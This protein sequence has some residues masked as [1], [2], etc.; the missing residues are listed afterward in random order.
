MQAQILFQKRK[1]R[2]IPMGTSYHLVT[3]SCSYAV[4]GLLAATL[5]EI[6]VSNHDIKLM[7]ARFDDWMLLLS[8]EEKC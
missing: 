1:C 7:G 4:R 2:H 6:R 3:T 8:C 5:Y